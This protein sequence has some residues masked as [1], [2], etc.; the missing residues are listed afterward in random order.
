MN[1]IIAILIQ[2]IPEV[3][4]TSSGPSTITAGYTM[5]DGNKI[6][7]I[8]LGVY[9]V[10]PGKTTY[11]AVLAALNLGYR[12]ID[13]A[14]FY[15]NEADVGRAIRDS[16]IPRS[17]IFV[18]T[19]LTD[20]H[21]GFKE[22]KHAGH[23]SNKTLGIGHIDL[24]LIHSPGM[25][26][27]GKI[28]ETWKALIELKK[29]GVTH[30]IGVSNFGKKHLE[31]LDKHGLVA[32][33]VN[34]FELHPMVMKDRSEV[35]E[36]CKQ[37]DILV[38]P[39]GSVLSGHDQLLQKFD[40]MAQKH[41]KTNA[42][43]LLRWALD[44]NFCVI[45]KSTHAERLKENL[46]VFDFSL[47]ES[48]ITEMNS[49]S[50]GRLNKDYWNPLDVPVN[51]GKS[52]MISDHP[53]EAQQGDQTEPITDHPLRSHVFKKVKVPP[54]GSFIVTDMKPMERTIRVAVDAN[55][56]SMH[57]D[58]EAWNSRRIFHQHW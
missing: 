45:P 5:N 28:V 32:P 37:H 29:E 6:P 56:Q 50:T 34:Q 26:A 48:E 12:M 10:K 38:Q 14:A 7:V 46:D 52:E 24:Y 9:R 11:D 58:E 21:H 2:S 33:A 31:A 20:L 57:E 47:S 35:V 36:Y 19:K 44:Q 8:G 1:A 30:S 3:V 51:E 49:L 16:G 41:R 13:T 40:G 15:E 23:Q 18:T 55:A 42:Q 17:E 43:L 53:S 39:Y 27:P 25:L 22:A 54:Q 4:A